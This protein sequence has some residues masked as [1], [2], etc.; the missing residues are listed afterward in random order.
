MPTDPGLVELEYRF[1]AVKER[2]LSLSDSGSR[3]SHLRDLCKASL[4]LFLVLP[5][6]HTH[7]PLHIIFKSQEI[8][9]TEAVSAPQFGEQ[10]LP[11]TNLAL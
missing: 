2:N 10:D 8:S 11:N 9:N 1:R 7:P 3:I 5:L 4:G 6:P